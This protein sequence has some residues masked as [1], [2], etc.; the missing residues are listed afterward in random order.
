MKRICVFAGAS[1]GNKKEYSDAA[2]ELGNEL[3]LNNIELVYGGGRTGLMGAIADSV[4]EKGGNA[5]G[6]IPKALFNKEAT[7]ENLTETFIVDTMHERKAKMHD[8]S[9]AFITLP[10]GYGTLEETLEVLTWAQLGFHDKPCGLLNVGQYY[11][12]LLIFFDHIKHHE[13]TNIK[14]TTLLTLEECPARLIS[15][16]KKIIS[17]N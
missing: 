11:D 15:R 3:V 9:D 10:G 2:I 6:V 5:I 12:P 1:S 13:F 16:L 4:I 8:L 17:T 7:H 14:D